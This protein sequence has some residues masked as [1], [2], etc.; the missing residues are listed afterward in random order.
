MIQKNQHGK[1][2]FL[3]NRAEIN[4][5]LMCSDSNLIG[6]I[7][8]LVLSLTGNEALNIDWLKKA[9]TGQLAFGMVR[10]IAVQKTIV[11]TAMRFIELLRS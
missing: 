10:L 9:K 5:S 2:L 4:C 3:I 11:Q 8:K 1:N 6:H 7:R